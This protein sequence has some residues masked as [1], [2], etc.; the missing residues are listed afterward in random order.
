V[1]VQE[2]SERVIVW[3]VEVRA[4]YACH[5][6]RHVCVLRVYVRARMHMHALSV[7]IF[8]TIVIVYVGTCAVG[9][10]CADRLSYHRL[11]LDGWRRRGEHHARTPW[12]NV[13]V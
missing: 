3:E 8:L 12:D 13:Q 1:N 7:R 4:T 5:T 9:V 6:F 2:R 11:P 10:V